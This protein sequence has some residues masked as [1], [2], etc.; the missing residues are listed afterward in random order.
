MFRYLPLLGSIAL[1]ATACIKDKPED[2]VPPDAT[3][4][5]NE[6]LQLNQIQVIASH[7][8][9][10][11][12][13]TD[14]IF[15][16]LTDL[17]AQGILPAN[18]NP[19]GLDYDHLNFDAQMSN[20]GVRGLEIDIYNDPQGNAY[21]KRKINSFVGVDTTPVAALAAPGFKV[22]HI[23]DVDYNT[24]YL[25][26]KSSLQALKNWSDA[27][28]AHLPIFVNIETKKDSP[29]DN[30]TLAGFGFQPA[31]GFDAAACDAL[32]A[33]IKSVFGASLDKILTPDKMR[34]GL[35][36]LNDVVTQKKFPKL[37]A[38]RGKIIFIIEGDAETP[39]KA[40]HPSLQGRAAFVYATAGTPE[41]AFV[42]LNG[43]VSNKALIEQRV[44]EG[45][46][47]RTRADS[48][49]EEARTGDYTAMNAAMASGAQIIS[50]DYYRPDPRGQPTWTNY[51]VKFPNG[52]IA[53]K[54]P[55]NAATINVETA[56]K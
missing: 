46:I 20:Y 5:Q 41:A 38:A 34:N 16:A 25:T 26:F 7:N 56:L 14:T 37:G 15:L 52:M 49:T 11:Q 13:T 53:R 4:L 17:Y 18:F 9:Y 55:R 28:P 54:N 48:D 42:I 44:S 2:L 35:P 45:Y 39:Y 40:G 23:K 21:D 6:Q 3:S 32:D 24:H 8:S 31:V 1:C 51:S 12:R 33:E 10:R 50:T 30:T 27:H 36:T 22:L 29:A 47:V 19:R 43:A